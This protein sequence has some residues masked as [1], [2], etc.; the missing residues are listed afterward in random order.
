MEVEISL[1]EA[2][3]GKTVDVAYELVD[4]CEHCHGNGAEPGTPIETCNRCHGSGQ[5]QMVSRTA[6]WAP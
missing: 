1:A 2:A 6:G 4:V 5:L 3:R